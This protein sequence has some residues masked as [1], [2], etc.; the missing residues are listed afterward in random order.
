MQQFKQAK[1]KIN[2]LFFLMIDIKKIKI[3]QDK[4]FKLKSLTNYSPKFISKFRCNW[5]LLIDYTI[6]QFTPSALISVLQVLYWHY[7]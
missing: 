4:L 7:R 5:C 6:S 1:I 2:C 3:T